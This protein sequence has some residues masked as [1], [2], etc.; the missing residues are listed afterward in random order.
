MG[1]RHRAQ[2]PPRTGPG[3]CTHGANGTGIYPSK[4]RDASSVA[5]WTDLGSG[6]A[7]TGPPNVFSVFSHFASEITCLFYLPRSLEA[8]VKHCAGRALQAGEQETGV[9]LPVAHPR[10]AVRL[11][12]GGGWGGVGEELRRWSREGGKAVAKARRENLCDCQMLPR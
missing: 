11:R 5:A 3:L 4:E 2:T 8:T 9:R 6:L 7:S 12:G 10:R 1:M